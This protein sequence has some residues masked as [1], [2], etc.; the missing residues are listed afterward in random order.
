MSKATEEVIA[1]AIRHRRE[2]K[3]SDA[4][5]EWAEAAELSRRQGDTPT[6]IR[7]LKGLAETYRDTGR[8]LEALAAYEE[9][10]LL[11]RKCSNTLLLA[12]TVRHLGDVRRH[13][14][15]NEGARS[16]Y[17]EALSI[18]RN[19]PHTNPLDLANA[20]RPFAILGEKMGDLDGA[21]TFWLEARELYESLGIRAGVDEASSALARLS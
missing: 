11:C 12:H 15:Q 4:A 19:T 8:N 18:Y 16:C 5:K 2:H 10:V 13:L 7:A 21:R 9:A 1:R 20:L 14:E 6:L 17:E 3:P